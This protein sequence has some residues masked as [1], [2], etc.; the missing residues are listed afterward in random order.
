MKR[1]A[2]SFIVILLALLLVV[3]GGIGWYV[4]TKQPSRS[5]R[6]ALERLSA[7]VQV[8]YDE[9]GV[10]HIS[11][12]NEADMYRAL[13]YVQ[14][15]DRLFQMEMLRRL[16]NGELAEVLGP[17]LID[18]DKLMRA[19]NLGAFA[20]AQAAALDPAKPSTQ[21][22]NAYLDGV[23]QF[24]E[25]H[26]KPLEF[27]I[28]HIPKR[29]FTV[30]DTLAVSAYFS[31]SFSP[32]FQT[33]PA[34]TFI[35]DQLGPQYLDIFDLPGS[36]GTAGAARDDDG[37]ALLDQL[38]L[39]SRK[40]TEIA[41]T[42]RLLGSN[43]WALSGKHTASSKPLLAGDP[44]ISFAAP[45]VWYEAHISCPGFDL[46]GHYM[47]LNPMALLGHNMAFGW[48]LTMLA[49][50]DI[51]LIAEKV[52]PQNP[53]QVWYQDKWVDMTQRTEAIHVKAGDDVNITL[54]Q[55]PHGPIVSD[56][57]ATG[58][59]G[60][61]V[62]M[63]WAFQQTDNQLLDAFYQL[64]RA[65]TLDLARQA[66]SEITAPGVNILWANQGGDIGW[67]AAGRIPQRPAG[68]DP[69]FMLD[70]AKGEADKAGFY[71]FAFNPQEENPPRGYVLSSNQ[72]PASAIPMPGYYSPLDRYQELDKHLRDPKQRWTQE[73]T[74]ALQRD[75]CSG[76]PG[77]VLDNLLPILDQVVT[78]PNDRA[79]LEPLQKWDGCFDERSVAATLFTQM[80]YELARALFAERLGKDRWRELM[81]TPIM[82]TAVVNVLATPNS[83]WWQTADGSQQEGNRF[84]VVRLA[85][86]ATLH[87]LQTLYG[88]SLLEWTW[89][90]AHTL[91]FTHV[92]G[93]QSPL[94]LLFNVGPFKVPGARE[95][96]NQFSQ[97]MGKAPWAV[98]YGPS[99]R[100]I[101]DFAQ[102]DKALG[103]SPLGQS[104]VL[105]DRHYADQTDTFLAGGYQPEHLAENDVRDHTRS[106]LVLNPANK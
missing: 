76:Y 23:N 75:V 77:R 53:N 20:R 12:Q 46:Y 17:K 14:A 43:A 26:P 47:A 98:T 16:A 56:A 74:K 60:D 65:A 89:D 37:W 80:E 9:R 70:A 101:I 30:A 67:W 93:R 87:H 72:K 78:D 91:T 2:I 57:I 7:P 66:S 21:A 29:P 84:E 58:S 38:A 50:A 45:A 5:G 68:V 36:P 105:F 25:G 94:D 79:F 103:I 52:N 106:T 55:S 4:Y 73:S 51:D 8:R 82:D 34:M 28:L 69:L 49:N 44:H 42:G 6:L 90:N 62:A 63:W 18:T 88:S 13:G 85:W 39:V 33:I 32:A 97:P 40:S 83:P 3:S 31:Y 99:T 104:G 96:P 24:Q 48:S 81:R 64:N 27:D 61:T 102:P 59:D 22:V 1:I 10:P 100:R 71:N 86:S 54:R 35:R 19:L 41:G 11:A 92:L 15:Q 95:T